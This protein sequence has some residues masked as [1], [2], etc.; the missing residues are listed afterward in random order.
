MAVLCLLYQHLQFIKIFSLY[1]ETTA[2]EAALLRR[3]IWICHFVYDPTAFS[4]SY[5]MYISSVGKFLSFFLQTKQGFPLL[6][7]GQMTDLFQYPMLF[8]KLSCG[9]VWSLLSQTLARGRPTGFLKDVLKLGIMGM[10]PLFFV[11]RSW[12]K[13]LSENWCLVS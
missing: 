6:S 8:P 3:I 10:K 5:F 4:S 2:S 1:S 7:P 13:M 12:A 11:A 9:Q